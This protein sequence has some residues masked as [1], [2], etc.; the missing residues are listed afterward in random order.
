VAIA[1][2]LVFVSIET[3][4]DNQQHAFQKEKYRRRKDEEQHQQRGRLVGQYKDGFNQSGLF[5]IVRKPNYAAE[6]AIW[7]SYYIFSVS[8]CFHQHDHHDHRLLINWSAI[9]WILLVLLFQGSGYFTEQIT[10]SKYPKYKQYMETTP[11]Y[12]PNLHH[13][14]SSIYNGGSAKVDGRGISD[15][16]DNKKRK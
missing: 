15:D 10:V 12:V 13:L 4:A 8:C 16:K 7:I 9:G 14:F 3:I 6:Q 11:L 2:F 5:S 1:L